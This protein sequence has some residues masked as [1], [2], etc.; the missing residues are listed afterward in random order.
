MGEQKVAVVTGGSA[1]IGEAMVYEDKL[2]LT[3]EDV[4]E[5]VRWVASLP[6]H[7]NIDTLGIMPADQAER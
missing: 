1:G 7:V 2:N 4:A 3:A 5:A 6:P